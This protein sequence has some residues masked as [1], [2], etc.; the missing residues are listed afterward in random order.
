MEINRMC[1][2]I[3]F[4]EIMAYWK[5]IKGSITNRNSE[6]KNIDNYLNYFIKIQGVVTNVTD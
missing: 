1:N 4:N 5:N 6:L 2:D 3:E